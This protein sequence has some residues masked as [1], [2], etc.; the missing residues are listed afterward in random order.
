[1]LRL[2]EGSAFSRDGEEIRRTGEVVGGV[3]VAGVAEICGQQGQQGLNIGALLMPEAEPGHGEP[4]PEIVR[5]QGLAVIEIGE[6]TDIGESASQPR[7][8]QAVASGAEE[9]GHVLGPGKRGVALTGV[10]TKGSLGRGVDRDE[11][12]LRNF[13]F[14]M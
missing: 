3:A 8:R 9:E 6:L 4:M 13:V 14:R 11:R 5:S 1:M 12:S 7:C 10:Q 2:H